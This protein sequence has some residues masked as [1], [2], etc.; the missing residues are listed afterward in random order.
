VSVSFFRT[1]GK[2]QLASVVATTVD[3]L[4]MIV[5]VS[6]LAV[7]GPVL[8]TVV[9]ASVGAI[10][11][12]SLNR[13]FTFKTDDHARSQAL[14]YALVSAGSLGLNAAGE[15]VLAHVLG[16][17]YIV[18]R[19]IVGVAVGLLWNFPLHRAF[20]FRQRRQRQP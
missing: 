5:L 12:F 10:T 7:A 4:T 20:V 3:Y 15:H 11:N 8:G 16:L 1:L 2:H 14:R 6:V 13:W 19:V 9:G 17:Q 18:A